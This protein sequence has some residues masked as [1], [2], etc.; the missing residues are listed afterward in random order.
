MTGFMHVKD[1]SRP[2][3]VAGLLGRA[4]EAKK[5]GR[6]LLGVDAK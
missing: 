2:A 5:K 1:A 4:A 6:K 3:E